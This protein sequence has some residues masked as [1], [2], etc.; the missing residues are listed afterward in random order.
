MTI[1]FKQQIT[2]CLE[3]QIYASKYNFTQPLVVM[4]ET[5][6]RSGYPS[7]FLGSL[8]E[9]L[10]SFVLFRF[11]L[12]SKGAVLTI[13]KIIVLPVFSEWFSICKQFSIRK[14]FMNISQIDSSQIYL[15]FRSRIHS[16]SYSPQFHFMNIIPTCKY[17]NLTNNIPIHEFMNI[18]FELGIYEAVSE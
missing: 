18:L 10:P 17:C 9:T 7:C 3:Q 4:L 12:F 8:Q 15:I 13:F 14:Q 5:F 6:R 2:V 11:G 16:Y 1:F